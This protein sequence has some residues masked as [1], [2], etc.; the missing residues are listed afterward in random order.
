[1]IEYVEDRPPQREL[2]A[3]G[4]VVQLRKLLAGV[5]RGD[6]GLLPLLLE[7]LLALGIGRTRHSPFVADVL[8]RDGVLREPTD[9]L[10]ATAVQRTD[11]EEVDEHRQTAREPF[12][13]RVELDQV[14]FHLA[15]L[16]LEL[17]LLLIETRV[18][19]AYS[20]G[21]LLGTI[22]QLIRDALG[23]RYDALGQLLP[24]CCQRLLLDYQA[25]VDRS[26]HGAGKRRQISFHPRAELI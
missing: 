25:F 22:K 23:F 3:D 4:I 7:L 21:L 16:R 20:R 1:M 17:L 9:Q 14:G 18:E 13:L 11:L 24:P 10:V 2:L 8:Q 12:D 26:T 15:A 19:C 5:R 6:A